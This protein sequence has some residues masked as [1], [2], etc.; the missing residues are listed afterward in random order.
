M[1]GQ[2]IFRGHCVETKKP[3]TYQE[4]I[5]LLRS[6]GC[7]VANSETA[8]QFLKQFNYYRF[9]GYLT[10]F[11]QTDGKFA[12]G[13]TF[14]KAASVCAFD[15]ELRAHIMKAVS[16]IE[17][18]VKSIVGYHHA[19]GYGALGYMN[20]GNFNEE[21][22]HECFMEKFNSAVH[23]NTNSLIVKHHTQKYDS[24]FPIWVATELFTMSMISIFYADLKTTDKKAIAAEYSTDYAHLK[25]WLHSASVLRNIC[26]HHSRLYNIRFHQNPK[27]PRQYRKHI[28]SGI[29]SLFR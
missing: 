3:T 14:E 28:G 11:M 2:F 27:L 26:A 8:I 17:I 21:H 10:A 5:E 23:N 18:T 9:S 12:K 15:H 29:Y 19:H 20:P 7:I 4:Q 24:K 25:S 1:R 6:R 13:F 22:D 16:G